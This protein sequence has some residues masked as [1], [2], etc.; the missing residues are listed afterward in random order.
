MSREAPET[1]LILL[2]RFSLAVRAKIP[3]F[4]VKIGPATG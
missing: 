2:T 4:S 3:G 1:I